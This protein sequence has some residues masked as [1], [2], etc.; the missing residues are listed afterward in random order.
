MKFRL[1]GR[2][3]ILYLTFEKDFD[4]N[5]VDGNYLS[6]D[7]NENN[8]T[9]AIIESFKLREIRRYETGLGRIVTNYAIRR[10]EI[11][12]GN[13]TKDKLVKKR[14]SEAERK[15]D[16]LRKTVKRVTDLA[17]ELN[18]KVV[19]GKFSSKAKERMKNGK[20]R[21]LRHRI[22]QWSVVNFVN[23]LENQPVEV[24]P[25]PEP[26]TSTTNPFNDNRLVKNEQVVEKVVKVLKPHLMTGSAHEGGGIKVVKV[27]GR[28]LRD[29]NLL[30]E[31]DC[32]APLNLVKKVDGRVVVFP[33]TSPD[34]LR[35]TVYDPSRGVP[36][37]ELKVIKNIEK[38]RH[39]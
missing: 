20:G 29:R 39:G 22:H 6:V 2:R 19:V 36:V 14:L 1:I 32:I 38:S 10:R 13:S 33:S 27:V 37:V 17:R 15:I 26:Y 4:V 5:I 11:T 16:I 30:L 34:E 3:A 25:I 8:V 21:R 28:Y 24:K 12:K 18:A 31:R 23:M 7:V 9:V 35:V